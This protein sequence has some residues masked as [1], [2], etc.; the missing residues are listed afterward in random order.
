M[1]KVKQKEL[2]WSENHEPSDQL[3]ISGHHP[4][5]PTMN[6]N[7]DDRS[8]MS[9]SEEAETVSQ[10]SAWLPCHYFDYMAGTSTGGLIG[11]ML[12]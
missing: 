1:E 11:I 3:A 9:I 2:E 10:P 5:S 8:S 7:T 4:A 6:L 12:V